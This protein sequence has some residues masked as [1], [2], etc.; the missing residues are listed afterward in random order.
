MNTRIILTTIILLV[1]FN[2]IAQENSKTYYEKM[3]TMTSELDSTKFS[4]YILY[5]RV[6][7]LANL[8]EFNQGERKDTSNVVHFFQALN[9]L[10]ISSNNNPKIPSPEKFS[11]YIFQ[12]KEE[13]KVSIGVLNIDFTSF[14]N[15]VYDSIN[16]LISIDS[17]TSIKKF[18]EIPNI[19]PYENKQT[20]IIS[21]LE[22]ETTQ[23]ESPV[24]FTFEQ[25]IFQGTHN[26]IKNLF[27]DFGDGRN[28]QIFNNGNLVVPNTSYTYTTSGIK[29]LT[30]SGDF[31]NGQTFG[32]YSTMHI[33]VIN[34]SEENPPIHSFRVDEHFTPYENDSP[35]LSY[36]D[37][38]FFHD[39]RPEI[40]FS[41]YYATNVSPSPKKIKKP[42]IIMDGIDYG[43]IRRCP[44]I[45]EEALKLSDTGSNLGITLN[46]LGYD[47][48]IVNFPKYKIA[49]YSET[50]L[51]SYD[52]YDYSGQSDVYE[53]QINSIFREGGA[54][55]IQRNAKGIKQLIKMVNDSLQ[56]NNSLE[57]LVVVGPSMGGQ[58]S[59]WALKELENEGYNHN[60]RIWVSFDS[61]HQGANIPTALQFLANYKNKYAA[62]DKLKR[63]AAKQMLVHHYL[64]MQNNVVDG[65]APNFR[66]RYKN[67]LLNLGYPISL[68]KIALVNGNNSGIQTNNPGQTMVTLH[69]FMVG[70][71]NGVLLLGN[72]SF[73]NNSGLKRTLH[74][75]FYSPAPN[76]DVSNYV[77]TQNEIGSYDNA[78]GC[79]FTM[80]G[81]DTLDS[82]ER[83]NNTWF[84]DVYLAVD[85]V[86]YSFS[87]MP[88]KSTLDF[89]GN[90]L[91]RE[92]IC[93]R[94]LV[95]TGETPFDSYY[96][97]NES[98]EHV[99]LN[100][101]N[102][103]WLLQELSGIHTTPPNLCIPDLTIEGCSVL[104]YNPAVSCTYE[105][106]PYYNNLN[107]RWE[108][109]SNLSIIDISDD[110]IKVH[111]NTA[112]D[113]TIA[114][115]TATSSD[116]RT[117]TKF[118][119]CPDYNRFFDVK[120]DNPNLYVKVSLDDV[121]NSIP[122][123]NQNISDVQ[124]SITSGDAQIVYSNHSFAEINGSE[125]TGTVTVVSDS[126]IIT[127]N[128]FWPDPDKC[129]AII[130][131][132]A[133]KYQ[134]KDRCNNNVIVAV[135]AEKELYSAYGYKL[136]D[137]P[138]INQELELNTGNSGDIQLIRVNTGDEELTKRIIKD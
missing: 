109:S 18:R 100:S 63:P 37:E 114:Q 112:N 96:A 44:K 77:I 3:K 84:Y 28:I 8:K 79:L 10:K 4:N 35:D 34:D 97:P 64:D 48:I 70:I 30:Y 40:E 29:T 116:N 94:N 31:F 43:D 118:I 25:S 81:K 73:S 129:K 87:F 123:S 119:Y 133:D 22:Q 85:Q 24:L 47:V 55:Y 137:L 9:E 78:P 130:K 91:L 23:K 12:K 136:S 115:I 6:F 131:V 95:T 42:I 60:T 38:V 111:R 107:I 5:D 61:P 59:R 103:D 32:T 53:T 19:L 93:D 110:E 58:V 62:L 92:S 105:I 17:T 20:L 21:T 82:F 41:I 90:S 15:E 50:V 11:R 65:G 69:S 27:L 99:A 106:E 101:E 66:D 46:N 74:L 104:C 2:L 102:V 134:V 121:P 88:T 117:A 72:A 125:F 71:Y 113:H 54:D 45:F 126:E 26:K 120:Y 127:K 51:V 7:P 49:E 98:E 56:V 108:V 1:S 36:V 68:R 80:T 33:H 16:N 57:K 122:L 89:Q 86:V 132:G 135:L 13:N 76:D 39:E 128:F 83:I 75:D 124:W 138:L 67:E 52:P 14:K